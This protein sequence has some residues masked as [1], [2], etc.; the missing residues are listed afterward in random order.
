VERG[1]DP[2]ETVLGDVRALA[3]GVRSA[4]R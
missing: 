4:R 2:V 1:A 3:E